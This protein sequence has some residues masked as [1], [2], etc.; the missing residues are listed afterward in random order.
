MIISLRGTNGA[1]KS[2][3]VRSLMSDYEHKTEIYIEGRRKPIGYRMVSQSRPELFIPGHYEIANG[4]IDTIRD[5]DVVYEMI[6]HSVCMKRHVIYEGKNMTDGTSRIMRLP[7]ELTTVIVIDHPVE[8]C[9]DSV[10]AR[11]HKIKEKTIEFVHR[12]ILSDSQK[13]AMNGF[14]VYHMSRELALAKCRVI[15]QKGIEDDRKAV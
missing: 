7:R 4:G 1:G 12:K 8:D 14:N 2:T 10:R 15:L 5:L 6:W 3:I 9:I 11:G 13:L